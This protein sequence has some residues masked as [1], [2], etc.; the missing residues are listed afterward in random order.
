MKKSSYLLIL[1]VFLA[2]CF[3]TAAGEDFSPDRITA[4]E[5]WS[6]NPGANNTFDGAIDLSDYIGREITVEMSVDLEYD[7]ETERDSMPVF[8]VINGK[9]ITMLKQ[10]NT[11]RCTPDAEKPSIQYTGRIT[12]PE[13]QHADSITFQFRLSD[14]SG[15][16]L[17]TVSCQIADESSEAGSA[18]NRFYIHFPIQTITLILGMTAA[19]VWAFNLARFIRIRKQKR[20]GES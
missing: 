10:T 3:C 17:K 18:G 5:E 19:L 4:G 15:L 6:W 11:I 7:A 2:V 8:T 14:E 16:E 12:L 1:T 9:R 20:T 13:K